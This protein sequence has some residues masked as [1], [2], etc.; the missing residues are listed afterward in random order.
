[1]SGGNIAPFVRLPHELQ[2]DT[3]NIK[4]AGAVAV[5]LAIRR[6]AA[7]RGGHVVAAP[8]LESIARAAR[9]SV[10]KAK[11]KIKELIAAGYLTKRQRIADEWTRS[12][13]TN[14]YSFPAMLEQGAFSEIPRAVI[15]DGRIIK[16]YEL[17]VYA[18][19]R[20]CMR[21]DELG[22]M[23][24]N[25][26]NVDLLTLA[27]CSLASLRRALERLSRLDYI[28]RFSSQGGR[29]ITCLYYLVPLNEKQSAAA[30]CVMNE[31]TPPALNRDGGERGQ[32]DAAR[33]A[34]RACYEAAEQLRNGGPHDV[35]AAFDLFGRAWN[36]EKSRAAGAAA[37]EFFKAEYIRLGPRA[38]RWCV[39]LADRLDEILETRRRA[40]C[41]PVEFLKRY[42]FKN[43][44]YR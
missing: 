14:T 10:T 24:C 27:H 28:R 19:L 4:D 16:D 33:E 3:E 9:C 15:D 44:Q 34:R 29:G 37:W 41:L 23:R 40:D 5:Y 26:G 32:N 13:L 12:P 11:G 31:E 38:R 18:A 2:K 43:N 25:V 7:P 22:E 36:G 42:S 17:S 35:K 39:L 1:M 30:A 6:F 20:Y 21:V 8:S